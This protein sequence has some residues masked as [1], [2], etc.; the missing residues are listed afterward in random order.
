MRKNEKQFYIGMPE[1]SFLDEF[2]YLTTAL[3]V[4]KTPCI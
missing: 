4:K 1:I 2:V 3:C